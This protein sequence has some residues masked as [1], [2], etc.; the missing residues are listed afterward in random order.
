MFNQ[1]VST[2]FIF[3]IDFMYENC[4]YGTMHDRSKRL[5]FIS[6]LLIQIKTLDLDSTNIV[7]LY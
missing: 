7:I 4:S 6:K 2:I 5:F 1:I 3:T